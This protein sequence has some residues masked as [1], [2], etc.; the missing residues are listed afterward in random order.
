VMP[1]EALE[2]PEAR[3]AAEDADEE[4]AEIEAANNENDAD[5]GEPLAHSPATATRAHRIIPDALYGALPISRWAQALLE[6][7]PFERLAGVSLS[8]APGELLFHAPFPSRLT[9]SLGVYYL[10]RQARPRDRA[11]HAAALAHDL[12]HGPFSH[13]TEPLMIERL[14][15]GHEQRGALLLRQ[16][17]AQTSGASARLL[18]WLDPDEVTALMLGEGADGRGKLLNGLM[19]YDNLDNVARFLQ[20][21][22]LGNASY[23]PRALARELRLVTPDAPPDADQPPAAPREPFVALAPDAATQA[24]A[25]LAD[26]RRVYRFLSES[27]RNRPIHGMLRKAVDLAAQAGMLGASFFDATDAQ[28]LRLLRTGVSPGAALLADAVAHDALYARIWEANAPEQNGALAALFA[29]GQARLEI[30]ERVATEAGLLPH[31]VVLSYTVA[32][33]ERTLPPILA[34][35]HGRAEPAPSLPAASAPIPA[36]QARGITL[37]VT[38]TAGRDYVRRAQ[39]AAERAL[40]PLGATPRPR[41]DAR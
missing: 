29:Q 41:P 16:S 11:L 19:D 13:L 6:L 1:D 37:L 25:W 23:D 32:R 20:S 14:G 27:A 31:E 10:A 39:M 30:E 9:H 26:R 18:A 4:V 33:G 17:L 12:G 24:R 15:I 38:P 2:T 7:A 34:T 21:A 22:G 3:D 36:T 40:G 8:D 5:D 35:P 28:A